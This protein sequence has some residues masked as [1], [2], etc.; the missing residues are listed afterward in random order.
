[1]RYYELLFLTSDTTTLP[2]FFT[3]S[4]RLVRV[5]RTLRYCY[6]KAFLAVFSPSFADSFL[7]AEVSTYAGCCRVFYFFA[8]GSN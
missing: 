3:R 5:G 2:H 1:M 8:V 4:V 7:H 6:L